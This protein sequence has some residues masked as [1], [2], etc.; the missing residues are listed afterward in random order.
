MKPLISFIVCSYNAPELI[1]KCINSILRQKYSGKK[2]IL[3]VDGGS[4]NDTLKVIEDMQ[5]KHREI[6]LIKNKNKLP[7][8]Y[9]MGKWLGWKKAKGE[10]IFIIDQDNELEG[11]NCVNEMLIP[12]EK[13]EVFG[14][15]CRVKVDYKD[16]LTNQY[17]AIMGTDPFLAYRTVDIIINLRKIEE[18][19]GKYSIVK[20]NPKNILITGGNCFVYRKKY[21][22]S[23][24]GYMQDTQN[25]MNL[26]NKRYDCVAITKNARTHHSATKGFFDFIRKKQKW[27]RTYNFSKKKINGFSYM[28]STKI[29]R[30]EFILN[31]FVIAT[32][33]PN[34]FIAMKKIIETREKAWILHPILSFITMFIYSYYFI[35]EKLLTSQDL[36]KL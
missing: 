7:E 35:T 20:I 8:G 27:A 25:V 17:V 21:L 14:C 16:S 12:F 1:A 31:L 18:D 11:D 29:Q 13:K 32:I 34:L 4:D 28:P 33:F 23:V 5:K 10:Y 24:G 36:K 9:G 30:K 3:I 26:V 15:L 22:D 6:I 19:C 2:Q